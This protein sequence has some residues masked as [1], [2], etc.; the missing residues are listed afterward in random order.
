SDAGCSERG[1]KKESED[2]RGKTGGMPGVRCRVSDAGCSERGG[3]KETE[4][5]EGGDWRRVCIEK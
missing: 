1:G 5:L 3:K 2:R 4:T